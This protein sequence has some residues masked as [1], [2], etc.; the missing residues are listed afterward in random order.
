MTVTHEIAVQRLRAAGADQVADQVAEWR[1]IDGT[2]GGWDGWVRG[3]F[4]KR[5]VGIIWP[6]EQSRLT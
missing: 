6:E 3:E 5:I 2:L 4:S 1:N